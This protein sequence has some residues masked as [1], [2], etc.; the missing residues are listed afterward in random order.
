MVASGSERIA[1]PVLNRTLLTVATLL[2][3]LAGT[4]ATGCGGEKETPDPETV[5]ERA[6]QPENLRPVL[7]DAEIRVQSLDSAD[8]V[9]NERILTVPVK[10]AGQLGRSLG[11]SRAGFTRL[12]RGVTY[13][14]E[15]T[16][17]GGPAD[18]VSGRLDRGLLVRAAA[19]AGS[20]GAIA[21]GLS[22]ETLSQGLAA[23]DFD[24]YA[25]PD[26][27]ALRRLDLT[28][29]L[30]DPDNGGQPTRIRFSLTGESEPTE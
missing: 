15:T 2:L 18:H 27:G 10:V 20:D 28:L 6:F 13:R 12:T 26:T 5:M 4:V 30:D 23:A 7:N 29:A 11:R 25:A 24:L 9:L 1:C 16:V 21:P 19:G 14:G 17:G 8:R 3:V 22:A